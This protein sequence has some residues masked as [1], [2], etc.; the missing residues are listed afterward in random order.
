MG[1]A[2]PAWCGRRRSVTARP[3]PSLSWTCGSRRPT[4]CA[5]VRPEV[6]EPDTFH[7]DAPPSTADLD[8]A[9]DQGD[10]PVPGPATAPTSTRSPRS[11]LRPGLTPLGMAIGPFSLAT[12]LARRPDRRRGPGRPRRAARRTSRSSRW[13]RR[14]RGLA[15]LAVHRSLRAQLEAG[16]AAVIVCEPAASALFISPRQIASGS[17]VFDR[18]V[19]EPLLRA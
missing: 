17:P 2:W 16:A 13:P 14:A 9:R 19:I 6:A 3:W 5:V 7:F 1:A 4:W 10:A 8:R 12:K 15:E 18:F 11:P